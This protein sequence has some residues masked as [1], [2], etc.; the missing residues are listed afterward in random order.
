MS[1]QRMGLIVSAC[2]VALL[3]AVPQLWLIV[4]VILSAIGFAWLFGEFA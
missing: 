4:L 3:I 2:F 1:Y